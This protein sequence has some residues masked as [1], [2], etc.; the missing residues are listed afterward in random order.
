MPMARRYF[1]TCWGISP[2]PPAVTVP[3]MRAVVRVVQ[4]GAGLAVV[5][6]Y[7]AEAGIADGSLQVPHDPPKPVLNSLY[8]AMRRGREH[9]PRV[10]T[11]FTELIM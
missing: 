3:D 6:L 10:R 1:R 7:L 5:P 11:V 2:Q 9:V 4:S 8:L